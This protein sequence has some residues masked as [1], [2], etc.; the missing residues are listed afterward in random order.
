[1]ALK[2]SQLTVSQRRL[3]LKQQELTLRVRQQEN[4]AKLKEVRQ[5]LKG[6]G[7]RIR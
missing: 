6:I 4:A 7:G 1:M 2:A 5:Q 3:Q